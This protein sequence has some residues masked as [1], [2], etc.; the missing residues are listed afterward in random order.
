MRLLLL[1]SLLAVPGYAWFDTVPDWLDKESQQL[2]R[3]LNGGIG[4]S[5][6]PNFI[7]AEYDDGV[8][9]MHYRQLDSHRLGAFGAV[10]ENHS[11]ETVNS[12]CSSSYYR[13]RLDLGMVYRHQYQ[14]S[15]GETVQETRI[16][17]YSCLQAQRF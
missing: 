12:F 10:V 16:D 7:N 17:R 2:V 3:D 1:L 6:N 13:K 9:I 4:Q 15:N 5:Q 14:S 8:M 11:Q